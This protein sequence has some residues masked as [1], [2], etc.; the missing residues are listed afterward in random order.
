MKKILVGIDLT[1][2]DKVVTEQAIALAKA[3]GASLDLLHVYASEPIVAG[4]APYAYPGV[5]ER[6]EELQEEKRQMRAIVDEVKASGVTAA[7]YM[8]EG[9]SAE[10]LLEYAAKHDCDLAVLGTHSRGLL[11]RA[12]LGSTTDRVVRKASIP[13][14]VVPTC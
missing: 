10:G 2:A 13:V 5:D 3:M 14:L 1:K 9:A 7:G 11:E 4:F 12:L 8:K 6:E